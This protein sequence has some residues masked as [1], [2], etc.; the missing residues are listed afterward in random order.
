MERSHVLPPAYLFTSLATM[1][2]MHFFIPVY[3]VTPAPWNIIG[4]APLALGMAL[5]LAADAALKKHGTTVKP[6]EESASLVTTGVYSYSRNPMYL[7]MIMILVGVALLMGS[8]S[9]YC[10][11]PVFIFI[12]NGSFIRPEESMLNKQFGATWTEYTKKVRRWL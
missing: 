5:N 11:I 3:E 6:F 7:G 4:L 10:I 9:P 8:L 1:V 2:L 12:M